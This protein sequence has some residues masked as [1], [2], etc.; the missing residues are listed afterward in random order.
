VKFDL[1]ELKK[2]TVLYVED[3]DSLREQTVNIFVN[4]FK[5]VHIGK[6]GNEGLQQFTKYSDTIDIVVSDINMPGLSGLEMSEE[7]HNLNPKMPII[8]TTA[9]TDEEYL[10]KSLELNIYKYMTKPLKIKD[11]TKDMIKAVKSYH[12]EENLTK[13]TK[14]LASQ[15]MEN[16]NKMCLLKEN[17]NTT[18]EVIN[19]QNR[20][21]DNYVCH[22]K[23]DSNA[24]IEYVS[25]KF[26]A[27]YNYDKEE[28]LGKNI[29][30]ICTHASFVQKKLLEAIREKKI[31]QFTD[32]FEQKDNNKIKL[33]SEIHP[34]YENADGLVSGYN[35]YQDIVS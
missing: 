19:I 12:L 5:E 28:M 11:L 25:N 3:E 1:L 23:I 14:N 16:Q 20:I 27:M 24:I 7:I 15:H 34:L 33:S 4:L 29:S 17:M 30:Q 31:I 6:D 21:I 9:Y 22:I 18:S 10:L 35:L 32:T 8:I 2:I 26:C 13:T